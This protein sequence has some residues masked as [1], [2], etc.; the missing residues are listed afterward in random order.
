MPDTPSAFM[1]AALKEAAAALGFTSPNPA[2]GAVI[3][4]DGRIIGRGR[5]QPPGGPH[6]EVIAL[7]EAGEAARGATL[8]STLE[9]CCHHGRT[10]PCTDAIM[11]AGIAEVHYAIDDPDDRVNG[12]GDAVLREA[13]LQVLSGDGAREAAR[14]L[15]GYLTHRRTGRPLVTVKFAAS[16]DGRIAS[17]SGDSR[18]VSGPEAREWAHRYRTQI[19]AIAVGAGTVV[20][21]D[22]ELTARPGGTTEG[23]HQPLRIVLDTR[24]RVSPSARVL[25]GASA[26]LIATTDASPEA[27]R[28]A[29]TEAGAEVLVLPIATGLV[30]LG[31]LLD[32]LG[33]RDVLE[34]LMEGGGVLHGSLFDQRLVNRLYA[35]IAPMVIGAANAATA[36]NG[37]GAQ[38]MA[39]AIRLTDMDVERLGDDILVTGI[40]VWPADTGGEQ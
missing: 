36:V 31:A 22:P 29:M 28:E 7:R 18:W 34:V 6:A 1:Q 5:T 15:E 32:H 40:P 25:A 3:V 13:G 27:W 37:H 17:A 10:P 12:G 11:A 16:L 4:R 30:D 26:T 33:K 19:D 14:Q 24:G 39:D 8:Y 35:V 23:A 21:D 2:V 20:I 38:T 9:P